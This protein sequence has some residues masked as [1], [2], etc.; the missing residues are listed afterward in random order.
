MV[1]DGQELGGQAHGGRRVGRGLRV[2]HHHGGRPRGGLRGRLAE[3]GTEAAK[4]RERRAA[5]EPKGP[6]AEQR[7]FEVADIEYFHDDPTM[8]KWNYRIVLKQAPR[9]R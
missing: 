7:F 1:S 9:G 4:E 6:T 5:G 3:H 2:G 8:K